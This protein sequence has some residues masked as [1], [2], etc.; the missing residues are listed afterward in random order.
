[1]E[2]STFGGDSRSQLLSIGEREEVTSNPEITYQFTDRQWDAYDALHDDS[3]SV[4]DLFELLYGGAKGGGKTVFGTR[5]IYIQAKEIIKEFDLKPQREIKNIPII[6]YMGRKRG[7]DLSSTTMMTWKREIPANAY[8]LRQ[9]EGR[10]PVIVIEN[11]VAILY[12][13]MD[14]TD[15]VKKF[16]SA[17]LMFYFIDQAEELDAEDLAM[18]RG[19]L[20]LKL[21][22]KD[23]DGPALAPKHGYKGLLTANPAKCFLKEMFIDMATKQPGTLF[24]KALPTDNPFLPPGYVEN[25]R[26]AFAFNPA[27]LKAYLEGLWEGLD[28][29][30]TVILMKNI[31]KCINSKVF[32]ADVLKKITV[33]D[34][35]G[36]GAD[37]SVIYDFENYKV[38]KEEIYSHAAEM[39]TCGRIVAHA[40]EHGSNMICIDKVGIGAGIYS[41]LVEIYSGKTKMTVYGY[42]GRISPPG[43][44]THKEGQPPSQYQMTYN[45][46]R[47]YAWF[48][49]AR[50]LQGRQACVPNDKMLVKQLNIV[51]Y[52]F[53]SN[54]KMTLEPKEDVVKKLKQSPDRADAF[55]MGLDALDKA[56][57]IKRRDR[58]AEDDYEKS[59]FNPDTV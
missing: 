30:M 23:K 53:Q 8:Q 52:K 33:A 41:R 15:T 44:V 28:E 47:S 50:K 17:E 24:V 56:E 1:M 22:G 27:L 54:G 55:V 59:T 29:A 4:N 39:D 36:E 7:V 25:L 31:E 32:K 14:N 58:W 12:G 48:Q 18:I 26:Q 43:P 19:T 51:N 42:D 2:D 5:W 34:V 40:T 13:G 16:N 3:L 45:N 11:R 21:K 46:Y 10:V 9:F 35:S 37:E 49:C 38:V 6:G 20:R 57:P